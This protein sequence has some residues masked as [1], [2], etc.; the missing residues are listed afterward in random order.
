MTLRE[1]FIEA[2]KK[3]QSFNALA[4]QDQEELL[5]SYQ[6]AGKAALKHGLEVIKKIEAQLQTKLAQIAEDQV[7]LAKE[8]KTTLQKLAKDEL[9]ANEQKDQQ[10]TASMLEDLNKQI[11]AL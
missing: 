7:K 6:N 8:I 5:A 2:L 10:T 11:D 9:Q 1:K 3:S 4:P